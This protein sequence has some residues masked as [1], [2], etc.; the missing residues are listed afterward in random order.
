MPDTA[1]FLLHKG[2][3]TMFER[4]KFMMTANRSGMIKHVYNTTK[5]ERSKGIFRPY[6]TLEQRKNSAGW[7][8]EVLKIQTSL[9]KSLY[10]NNFDELSDADFA[11]V[12]SKMTHDLKMMDIGVFESVL[13]QAEVIG[14]H[15]GKNIVLE[16]GMVP[17]SIID[18]IAQGDYFQSLDINKVEYRN[19]GLVWKLHTNTFEL[20]LYDKKAD[21][22]QAKV[23]E[24]RCIEKDNQIQLNLFDEP[25]KYRPMEVLRMEVRLNTVKKIKQVFAKIGLSVPL[26][27]RDMCNTTIE[28]QVLLHYLDMIEQARPK[29]L[30]YHASSSQDLL[31]EIRMCNP[32]LP[33][34]DLLA[35][36]KTKELIDNGD[37][38][39]GIREMIGAQ[40]APKWRK[41][42]N[43]AKTIQVSRHIRPLAFMRSQI[44]QY[45]PLKLVD[46][47]DELLNNDN[48]IDL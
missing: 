34:K 30:D 38:L 13:A 43:E 32:K 31:A 42:V 28:K 11:Q 27:F 45:K 25:S 4:N 35:F 48:R 6:L 9:P 18:T 8:D 37:T 46:F 29:Y 19:N 20:A 2:E 39:G 10:G 21:L 17:K 40:Y 16:N 3:Y 44:E 1:T 24:K 47:Q 26:T 12:L 33:P 7:D 22:Q 23:S 36:V 14:I 41:L 5:A 15:Y